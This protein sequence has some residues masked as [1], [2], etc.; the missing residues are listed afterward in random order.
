[1]ATFDGKT[2]FGPS[3]VGYG[4][5]LY[6]D[7]T[8]TQPTVSGRDRPS[9]SGTSKLGNSLGVFLKLLD[10]DDPAQVALGE[11]G[12]NEFMKQAGVT[13]RIGGIELPTSG[14]KTNT[15]LGPNE[16]KQGNA[17]FDAQT[18]KFLRYAK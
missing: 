8:D 3:L 13:N 12:F 9:T 10:S 2:M 15:G 5:D 18:K 7:P 16:I 11:A 14:V 4:Q 6:M 1:M 17:I